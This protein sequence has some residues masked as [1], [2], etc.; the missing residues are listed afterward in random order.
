MLTLTQDTGSADWQA[1][2]SE[3]WERNPVLMSS[4]FRESPITLEDLYAAV[5][6]MPERGRFD[7]FWMATT[8][9]VRK[10]SDFRRISLDL[11]GPKASDASFAGFFERIGDHAFGINIHKLTQAD[12]RFDDWIGVFSAGT[13]SAPGPEPI[14]WQSDTFFGTYRA[15][16]FGI[17]RDPAG[18]FSYTLMGRRTYYTWPMDAFEPDHPDLFTPDPDVLARHLDRAEKFEVEAGQALYWP[19]NRWHLVAS[20]GEPFVVVQVSAHF[21]PGDVGQ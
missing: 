4:G 21:A 7:R 11:I 14:L 8:S 19:S 9:P 18:V 1:F 3:F 5:V 17:H 16:P 12:Q 20:S 13:A 10:R 2:N 15:T 6:N